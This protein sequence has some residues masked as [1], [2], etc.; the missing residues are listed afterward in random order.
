LWRVFQRLDLLD[1]FEKTK[2]ITILFA[3]SAVKRAN[4]VMVQMNFVLIAIKA[5]VNIM[6]F[7]AM[8]DLSVDTTDVAKNATLLFSLA[9]HARVA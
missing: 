9:S 3:R 2:L 4:F 6:D 1:F 8:E 5:V 7:R